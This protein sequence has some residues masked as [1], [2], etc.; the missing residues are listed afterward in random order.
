MSIVYAGKV[1]SQVVNDTNTWYSPGEL[2]AVLGSAEKYVIQLKCTNLQAGN[3][4]VSLQTSE[5]DVNWV[6]RANLINQSLTTSI[7]FG[8]YVTTVAVGGA[9][10]RLGFALSGGGRAY[11]E[12]WVTARDGF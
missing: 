3:V 9:R 10:G 6:L 1:F 5:D 7:L 8:T 11:L 4:I 2:N 12:C